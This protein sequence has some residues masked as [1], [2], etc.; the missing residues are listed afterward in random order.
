[1]IQEAV[2]LVDNML[3]GDTG[4]L[5]AF[6]SSATGLLHHYTATVLCLCFVICKKNDGPNPTPFVKCFEIN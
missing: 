6:L 2:W 3:D 5:G 1:M 4:D